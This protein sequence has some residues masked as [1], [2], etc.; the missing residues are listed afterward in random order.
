MAFLENG[1]QKLEPEPRKRGKS[2]FTKKKR[3]INNDMIAI[4]ISCDP[5]GNKHY[6]QPQEEKFRQKL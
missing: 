6:R 3:G 4:L 5:K 2:V 1:N